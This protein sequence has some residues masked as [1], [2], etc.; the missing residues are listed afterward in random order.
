MAFNTLQTR[1]LTILEENGKMT[2]KQIIGKYDDK[3]DKK[4]AWTTTYDNLKVLLDNKLIES[5][6]MPSNGCRGAPPVIWSIKNNNM[7]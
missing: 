4:L 6:R 7:S 1:L 5:K 3:Y 2:R